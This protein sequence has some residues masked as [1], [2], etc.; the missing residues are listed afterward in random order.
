[1]KCFPHEAMLDSSVAKMPAGIF[2]QERFKPRPQSI[3]V[4]AVQSQN[5]RD[6]W[7]CRNINKLTVIDRLKNGVLR[8]VTV[9]I[10][11]TP[12]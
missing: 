12:N 4:F 10:R 8:K 7:Y 6:K 1:M 11:S 2:W 5:L 3:L 9:K